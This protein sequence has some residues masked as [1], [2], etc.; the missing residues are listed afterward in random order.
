MPLRIL[1]IA[2]LAVS[3]LLSGK[4]A[5]ATVEDSRGK[6]VQLPDSV[7]HVICSGSGC[8]R[9]LSYLQAQD[10][11]VGVDSAETRGG[12]FDARPYALANPQFKEMPIFGEFRGYDNPEQILSLVPAPQVIFKTYASQMGYDPVELEQKTGIPVVSLNY[13]NLTTY[14]SELYASLR[15]MGRVLGKKGRVEE[16]I[17][18]FEATIADLG[19][20]TA[21]ITGQ[22]PGVFLGGVA[23]KGPHG[24]QSTEP[25]YPPFKF[26]H[27][28][29]LAYDP[30]MSKKEL[31]NASIAK[32]KIV[33]LNPDYLFLDLSTL[34]LGDK[35]G[36]LYELKND[37]AYGSLTAVEKGR[38]YGLLPYNW[39]TK[40][41]GS[42]LANAYFIGKLLYPDRFTDVEPAQK[43]DEIYRFLVGKP[44]FATMD[45]FFNNLA[46]KAIP[47][48]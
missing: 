13:G 43:A 16:L 12:A 3:V 42:I 22:R 17:A 14:R 26:V 9:L 11:I 25:A 41:Y 33:V 48:Q 46:F 39:Y 21:E 10:R 2:C 36:G 32:E 7:D 6:K 19:S 34:Q 5:A 15:I 27:A 37:P 18:F 23:F 28:R 31:R 29:N 45:S 38:V 44:V 4:V 47:L 20:R 35:A 1:F 8:L 24:L 30:S 40:N